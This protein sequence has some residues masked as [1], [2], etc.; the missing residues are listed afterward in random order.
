MRRLTKLPEPDE[1]KQ[2]RQ[3]WEEMVSTSGSDYYKTKYRQPSIK[4]RLT[5]ETANKCVYCESK[6]G[7]NTPGDVEHKIP[8][9]IAP[10]KRFDWHNLTIACTE[11]NRRKNDYYDA[12]KP[13]V[14]PYNY[15]VE[16]LIHHIGP[17]VFAQPGE[18]AVET[19]VRI[20]ELG[21]IEKRLQLFYRKSDVIK[22]V[23]HLMNRIVSMDSNPL[24]DLLLEELKG[25]AAP[26]AEYSAMVRA[27]L[28]TT[29]G[30]WST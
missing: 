18:V 29:P 21:D 12:I 27:I 13:F 17:C 7:H 4:Q 3:Y 15:D 16:S 20:L 24:R 1:L 25:M 6:I 8:V 30:P 23:T 11:C 2:N 22:A 5:E 19:S 28:C 10:E 26:K 9:S 14:D